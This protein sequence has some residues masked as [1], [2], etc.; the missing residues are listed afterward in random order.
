MLSTYDGQAL[1]EWDTTVFN[2][3]MIGL[4][5]NSLLEA[6]KNRYSQLDDELFL[7]KMGASHRQADGRLVPTVTGVLM[8]GDSSCIRTLFPNYFLDYQEEINSNHA[9]QCR[10]TSDRGME[11]GNIFEFYLTV[12]ER[13]S[14]LSFIKRNDVLE[15]IKQIFANSLIHADYEGRRGIVVKVS[16]SA[17]EISNPG[18]TLIPESQIMKG[19]ISDP[20]NPAI[21]KMFS[22]IGGGD[23]A[24]LGITTAHRVWTENE[25]RGPVFT[26]ENNPDRVSAFLSFR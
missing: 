5:R 14:N 11:C 16:K 9:L 12:Y 3:R 4:Y 6:Y 21:F 1:P 8:F 26:F 23:R 2:K 24:G 15:P 10:I 25:W 7:E 18:S 20:R 17:I 22:A 13:L 19:G